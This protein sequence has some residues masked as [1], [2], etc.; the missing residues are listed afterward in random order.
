MMMEGLAVN[1]LKISAGKTTD[2]IKVTVDG[3]KMDGLTEIRIHPMKVNELI[4]VTF[5]GYVSNIDI[6]VIGE[7]K[8]LNESVSP[9]SE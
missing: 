5:T 9:G 4:M 7:F 3:V 2:D 6:D 1:S 8:Q